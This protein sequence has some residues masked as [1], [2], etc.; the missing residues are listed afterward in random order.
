MGRGTAC[1]EDA[2][3]SED[4]VRRLAEALS[5]GVAFVSEGRVAWANDALASMA[6]RAGAADLQGL[7]LSELVV[8]TGAGLPDPARAGIQRCG[9]RQPKGGVRAVA[10]RLSWPEIAPGT[11]AWVIEDPS[12]VRELEEELL[13][14]SQDLHRLH[15]EAAALRDRLH[16]E[17]ATRDE[18][19]AI[20]SHELRTPVTVIGGYGRI[21]LREEVGSLTPEQRRFLEESNKACRRLDAFI[22]RL[23]AGSQVAQGGEVLEVRS[24]GLRLLLE[25]VAERMQPLFAA[26]R[27][28]LV[29]D[30][31]DEC[32][33]RFD[34]MR[35][36]QVLTN[37][38][39]NA[40]K[41][42]GPDATVEVAARAVE[43]GGRPMLEVAVSDDGP[44]IPPADRQRVFQAYVRGPGAA[45]NGL[46][47]GLALCKRIVEGHGGAIS[48]GDRPGGGCRFAFTLPQAEA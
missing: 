1:R 27:S 17:R 38:L 5:E 24:G 2:K 32:R 33:A 34:P 3:R 9:L 20:V 18:L 39:D 42:A 22:D 15:R 30:A 16:H 10:W 48:I 21:L 28:R 47:L 13:R 19:L 8:D 29:L 41:Y 4:A 35:I 37:L 25:E 14:S 11:D 44:G 6:A 45:A 31:P 43:C 46:G 40:L 12:R 7:A 26:R 23:L 36:E